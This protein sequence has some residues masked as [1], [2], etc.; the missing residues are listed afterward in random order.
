MLQALLQAKLVFDFLCNLA[1]SSHRSCPFEHCSLWF[2]F[3]VIPRFAL[4]S[5]SSLTLPSIFISIF[6]IYPL[7]L[8]V[9]F[10]NFVPFKA[11][12]CIFSLFPK[13]IFWSSPV[14]ASPFICLALVE[15]GAKVVFDCLIVLPLLLISFRVLLFIIAFLSSSVIISITSIFSVWLW[16]IRASS[17]I[18]T[19]SSFWS[20]L[21][22]GI[23]FQSLTWFIVL[24]ILWFLHCSCG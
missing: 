2:R 13:I 16:F 11:L 17:L 12:L 7:P 20:F 6:S 8:H 23:T 1:L 10:S 9:I 21:F 18:A 14:T 24:A 19:F 3:L 15:A 22:L 5:P 4:W